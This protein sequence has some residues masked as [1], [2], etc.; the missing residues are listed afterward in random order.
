[1]D[2]IFEEEQQHLTETYGQLVGIRDEMLAKM[3]ANSRDA[4]KTIGDMRDELALDFASDD[5][6]MET[7]ADYE[8]MNRI[9]DSYNFSSTI[10]AERLRRAVQLLEQ[11]YFAKV[12]LQFRPGEPVKDIYL[13]VAGMTN[14]ERRHFI[15]DWRSP[16]AEVY[17]NQE[18]GRTSYKANGR[19]IQVDLLCRRQFD[20][21]RDKLNAY[22]DTTVAIED[23]L[24]MSALSK[25]RSDK[26]Q[27]ITTTIQKEQNQVIRHDDVP[28]LLVGGIA[29]SGKTSVLLQRIAYL[30][31]QERENLN[32]DDVFLITPNPVFQKYIDNVLPDMG[33]RNPQTRTYA[34]LMDFLGVQASGQDAHATAESLKAIDAAVVNLKLDQEDFRD[35]RLGDQS[36]ISA[37]Q[38]R[39]AINKHKR[40]PA[41]PRLFALVCE[42][43]HERLEN[44][45]ASLCTSDAVHGEMLNLSV[46]EQS[47]IFGMQIHPQDEDDFREYAQTYLQ[48]KY[49][50]AFDAIE[51]A[52]W[53]R[54][55]RIGMR[56]LGTQ[57]LS[58]I[59]WLHLKMAVTGLSNRHARFVMV[60]EVQ[61]YTAA[62]LMVLARYFKNAHF[63]L[64]GDENQAIRPG[65]ASFDEVREVFRLTRGQVDECRLMTSYRSTPEI[66]ELFCSLMDSQEQVQVRSVQREGTP[67]RLV[68]CA[69]EAEYVAEL[70]DIVANAPSEGLTAIVVSGHRQEKRLEQLLGDECPQVM[71]HEAQ[72]PEHGVILLDLPLAKGLEFDRVVVADA[73]AAIYPENQ[74]SRRRLYTAISR[75]TKQVT[76][77][78]LGPMTPLLK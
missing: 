42:D 74:L 36:V 12:S 22:F 72:L 14:D 35:I 61:D 55:N 39:S 28:A 59:E 60:D 7:L 41:G 38:I 54:L 8:S 15:V 67:P 18:N 16:V 34:Q 40:I 11:P 5:M 9:I 25:Q 24:L 29:G 52:E 46:E 26:M 23:P 1:M 47:Q 37:N 68:E 6:T 75:A 56:L 71:R 78:S 2:P 21:N 76:V 3:E 51:N 32:P 48:V 44:R 30:F 53:L 50:P 43:L 27:A 66:T 63:L 33:E 31:Y 17:Y 10:N 19:T 73:S 70:K 57:D 13:G 45:L 62:Q 69:E 4:A 77:M 49:A 20:I 64:L 58:P 65:T